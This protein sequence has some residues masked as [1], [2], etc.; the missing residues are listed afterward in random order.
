MPEQSFV[1]PQ[2][3]PERL[4]LSSPEQVIPGLPADPPLRQR[5]ETRLHFSELGSLYMIVKYY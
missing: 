4:R 3:A 1:K 2:L 5:K